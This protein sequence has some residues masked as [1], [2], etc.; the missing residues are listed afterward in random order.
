MPVTQTRKNGTCHSRSASGNGGECGRQSKTDVIFVAM[1]ALVQKIYV[2]DLIA[3]R[4][5]TA[6]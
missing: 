6:M 3:R 5:V 1:D 2:G 4:D